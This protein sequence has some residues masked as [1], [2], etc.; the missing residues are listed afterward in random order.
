MIQI[1]KDYIEVIKPKLEAIEKVEESMEP[2]L[3]AIEKVVDVMEPKLEAIKEVEK[4][5]L[6]PF[7]LQLKQVKWKT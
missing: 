2:K 7:R 1:K 3:D 6:Q 4:K 5:I